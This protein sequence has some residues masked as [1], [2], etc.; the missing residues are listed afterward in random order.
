MF[1]QRETNTF[2]PF[3]LIDL[4]MCML[5]SDFYKMGES[6]SGYTSRGDLLTNLVQTSSEISVGFTP[7][8]YKKVYL[9]IFECFPFDCIV[10][11][12]REVLY[13]N[14]GKT[15][16]M[17]AVVTKTDFPESVRNRCVIEIWWLVFLRINVA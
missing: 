4:N 1:Y 5:L 9:P 3:D 11:A 8:L 2:T 7:R 16:Q 10:V 12:D 6:Y 14:I 15:S 13:P 17:V